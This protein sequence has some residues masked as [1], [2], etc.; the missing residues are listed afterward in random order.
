MANLNDAMDTV[1]HN[2]RILGERLVALTGGDEAAREPAKTAARTA[3]AALRTIYGRIE[4]PWIDTGSGS[5]YSRADD[6]NHDP[7]D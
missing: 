1:Q 2:V 6:P 5:G 7:R 4:Q 3:M